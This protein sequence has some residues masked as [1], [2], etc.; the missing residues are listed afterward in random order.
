MN[1]MNKGIIVKEGNSDVAAYVTIL[2][3]S[4]VIWRCHRRRFFFHNSN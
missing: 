3:E 1:Q 4:L 2:R